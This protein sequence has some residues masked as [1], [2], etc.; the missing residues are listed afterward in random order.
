MARGD[1]TPMLGDND[2]S[3]WATVY[4]L[5]ERNTYDIDQTPWPMTI[6]RVQINGRNYSSKPPLLPT[7]LAGEYLLLKKLSFG[8]I[9]F[10]RTPEI[11]IHF[12][13]G[14]VNLIPLL[15]FLFLYSRFLDRLDPDP[16]TRLFSMLAAG[17]G[18]YL[19]SYSITLN[20]HTLAA[21]CS[22]F[23]LY[24]A[25]RI[26][27]ENQRVWWLYALAGFFS[28]FAAVNEFPA[29]SLLT[30]MGAGLFW[31]SPKKTLLFFVPLALIPLSGHFYTNYLVT[32]SWKPAYADNAAY[33][34]PGSYW[35]VDP[36]SGR[37]V[38][39][40]TDPLTG[41]TVL[42]F[43]E[44]IDNQYEPWPVYLFHMVIGHHGIFSLS[45]IFILT[46]LGLWRVMRNSRDSLYA[47]G[48]LAAALTII[49]LCFYLFFAGHRN[50]GG[51]CNGLR[52][53]FWLIPLWL[54]FAPPGDC[55]ESKL[56]LV[57]SDGSNL[58][59]DFCRID[60]LCG[61]EPMDPFLA[62]RVVVLLS[63]DQILTAFAGNQKVYG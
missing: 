11:A 41:K 2:L 33:D 26:W 54:T 39:S 37:L 9:N 62:A 32:G 51:I 53:F 5:A 49:L 42:E 34:F 63:M 16:W 35:K 52:W 60:L 22:F 4:S 23:A 18:T 56:P 17:F 58:P 45:P 43:S 57:S 3:R 48:L 44:G 6:D 61:K 15:I 10:N 30:F 27:V 36:Q 29:L 24:A 25:Y 38:G 50:Y 14:T 20:N 21:F 40:K 55:G 19:T 46:L 1:R 31:K 7:L 13:L 28:A 12:L 59:G 47:F 8:K